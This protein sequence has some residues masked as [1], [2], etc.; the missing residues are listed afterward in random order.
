[1]DNDPR[2]ELFA[3]WRT[4]ATYRVRVALNL[5]GLP[6]GPHGRAR[7]RSITSW[8]LIRIR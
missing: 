1:M 7:V 5:K 6:V 2:F 3:F 4:S 8:R